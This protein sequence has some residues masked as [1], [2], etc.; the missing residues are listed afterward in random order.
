VKI[1]NNGVNTEI[2]TAAANKNVG[3]ETDSFDITLIAK[4]TGV[5]FDQDDIKTIAV[6]KINEVLSADKYLLDEDTKEVV[7]SYKSVDIAN[8]T[9]VLTVHF[10]TVAAYRV[11]QSNLSKILSG[12]T[13]Q[14]I[15]EIM[16]SKPEV[17]DVKIEFWPS[18]LVHKAPRLSGKI[19]IETILSE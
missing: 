15:R 9:G 2:L 1:P 8:G 18:W 17:D 19:H 16:L 7:A 12:K 10:E 5:G 11:D 13:E 14:E 4:F 3:D 6:D